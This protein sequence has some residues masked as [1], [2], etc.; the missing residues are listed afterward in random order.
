MLQLTLQFMLQSHNY[1]YHNSKAPQDFNA[2]K[3]KKKR[4]ELKSR[5]TQP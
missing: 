1:V 4:R 3:T 2:K 5:K